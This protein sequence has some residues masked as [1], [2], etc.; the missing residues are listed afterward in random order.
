MSMTQTLSREAT[1]SE[2]INLLVS[3]DEKVEWEVKASEA[4]LSLS[5]L[6]RRATNGYDAE[7]AIEQ[8]TLLASQLAET[9]VRVGAMLD[10]TIERAEATL[11]RIESGQVAREVRQA[12]L[13]ESRNDLSHAREG[14]HA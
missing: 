8:L 4:G 3:R 7:S 6:I 13:E 2:R 9:T 14:G 5:E 1:R 10:R 11:D 12:A